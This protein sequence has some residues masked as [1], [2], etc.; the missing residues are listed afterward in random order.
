MESEKAEPGLASTGSPGG[1]P[2]A[3]SFSLG[4]KV[5]W[6]TRMASGV[7]C[8]WV[9]WQIKS[10]VLDWEHGVGLQSHPFGQGSVSLYWTNV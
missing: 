7:S 2:T 10:E 1:L 8:L 6:S 3:C 9:R 4:S 5:V